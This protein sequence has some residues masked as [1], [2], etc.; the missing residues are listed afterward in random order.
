MRLASWLA[1][2]AVDRAA[3]PW[4]DCER[5]HDGLV[6][7][8]VNT[9]SS[10]AYVAAGGWLLSRARGG[11]DV[12]F[13]AA[14]VGVGLGSVAFHGPG[15]AVA[16]GLHDGTIVLVALTGAV[17]VLPRVRLRLPA[18]RSLTLAVGA[19]GAGVVFH[20]LGRTASTVCRSDSLFQWH[21]LWHLS[22]AAALGMLG[23]AVRAE[24]AGTGA[25]LRERVADRPPGAR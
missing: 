19:L 22:T 23:A 11:R 18:R 24:P 10:L 2:Q 1:A 9:L 8:P 4:V 5:L 20:V 14:V 13:G 21:A 16:R 25:P 17:A 7:Q 3:A 15:G 12:A 6:A